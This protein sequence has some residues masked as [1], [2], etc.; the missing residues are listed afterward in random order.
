MLKGPFDFR[1]F[2]E[3]LFK[4]PFSRRNERLCGWDKHQFKRR[5]VD[6]DG[7]ISKAHNVIVCFVVSWRNSLQITACALRAVF[8]SDDACDLEQQMELHLHSVCNLPKWGCYL[9]PTS[10]KTKTKSSA[11]SYLILLFKNEIFVHPSIVNISLMLNSG[12]QGGL[13]ASIPSVIGKVTLWKIQQW[14]EKFILVICAFVTSRAL[15][16]L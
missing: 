2:D 9:A 4:L 14:S 13:Q 6:T 10:S 11:S 15:F 7:V 1:P 8:I 5:S 3:N 16:F 12:S